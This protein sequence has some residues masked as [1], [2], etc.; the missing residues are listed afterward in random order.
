M[1][2]K[3]DNQKEEVMEAMDLGGT[4]EDFMQEFQAGKDML[5][6]LNSGAATEKKNDDPMWSSSATPSDWLFAEE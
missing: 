1:D 5:F 2:N 6:S 3:P 4:P